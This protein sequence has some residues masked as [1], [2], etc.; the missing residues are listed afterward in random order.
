[1]LSNNLTPQLLPRPCSPDLTQTVSMCLRSFFISIL[2]W[3]DSGTGARLGYRPYFISTTSQ[4]WLPQPSKTSPEGL[5]PLKLHPTSSCCALGHIVHTNGIETE[6]KTRAACQT[7]SQ[8]L[9]CCKLFLWTEENT[10]RKQ[11]FPKAWSMPPRAQ[12]R[13]KPSL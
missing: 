13:H 9:Y 6:K 11:I 7:I 12:G 2:K 4:L 10:A 1:M 8:P 3:S 5:V